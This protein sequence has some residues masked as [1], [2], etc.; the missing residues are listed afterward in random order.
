MLIG[1]NYNTDTRTYLL[2]KMARTRPRPVYQSLRPY[3]ITSQCKLTIMR[4]M[5]LLHH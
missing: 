1:N 5:W 3:H 4:Q 2:T